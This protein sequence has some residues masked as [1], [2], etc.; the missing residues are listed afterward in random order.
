MVFDALPH[1]PPRQFSIPDAQPPLQKVGTGF[2]PVA[3][4][5]YQDEPRGCI[6][7]SKTNDSSS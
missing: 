1:Y 2:G 7:A 4:R 3:H 5:D 6:F